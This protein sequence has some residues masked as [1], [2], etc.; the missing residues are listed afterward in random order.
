LS[1][2]FTYKD[3]IDNVPV[4]VSAPLQIINSPNDLVVKDLTLREVHVEHADANRLC[5]KGTLHKINS[6]LTYWE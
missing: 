5:R 6:V 1:T 4:T 3:T 2:N